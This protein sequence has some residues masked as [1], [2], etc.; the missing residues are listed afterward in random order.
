MGKGKNIGKFTRR[1]RN[2]FDAGLAFAKAN[3]PKDLPGP[4]RNSVGPLTVEAKEHR[5]GAPDRPDTEIALSI[6]VAGKTLFSAK[7][8]I[9]HPGRGTEERTERVEK[10]VPGKWETVLATA[11]RALIRSL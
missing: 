7:V 2:L 5:S 6:T 4:W 3:A 8:T 10:Y 11:V 9:G 1:C